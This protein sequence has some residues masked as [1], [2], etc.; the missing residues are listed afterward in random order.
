MVNLLFAC[1]S[2]RDI[3]QVLDEHPLLPCDVYVVKYEPEW[4]AYFQIR[5]FFL[6]HK[7]YTHLAIACDDVVVKPNHI[8]RIIRDLELFDYEVMSGMMNVEQDDLETLNITPKENIV[9]PRHEERVYQWLKKKDVIG[10]G[11]IEVG[12]SG[13]PLMVIRRN[14]VSEIPFDSDGAFN[15]GDVASAGSL[16]VVFCKACHDKG[17]PIMV[18]TDILLLHMRRSGVSYVGV[19]H[20]DWY[21]RSKGSPDVRKDYIRN[22]QILRN[23]LDKFLA[24]GGLHHQTSNDL[25]VAMA[26][27]FLE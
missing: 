12:F 20:P 19:K 6:G 27:I 7:E 24:E 23:K 8:R 5:E 15:G 3:P 17:I 21:F 25:L 22:K 11:I 14:I 26:N 18:D 2:P 10:K 9:K 16:D 13:F 1:P 4:Q